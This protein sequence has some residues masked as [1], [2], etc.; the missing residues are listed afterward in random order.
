MQGPRGNRLRVLGTVFGA[1]RSLE[2]ENLFAIQTSERNP[3]SASAGFALLK[4]SN[5][6]HPARSCYDSGSLG[7]GTFVKLDR[8]AITHL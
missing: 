1:N 3:A 5:D 2:K 8:Q 4:K 6:L 7:H